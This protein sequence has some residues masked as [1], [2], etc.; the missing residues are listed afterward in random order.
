MWVSD[1]Y[2]FV[3][4]LFCLLF[5]YFGVGINSLVFIDINVKVLWNEN[6]WF[7]VNWEVVCYDIEDWVF[8]LD[9]YYI[10]MEFLCGFL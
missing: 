7:E 4:V 10:F 3:M 5:L 2:G 9:Y 6:E 8:L 1:G